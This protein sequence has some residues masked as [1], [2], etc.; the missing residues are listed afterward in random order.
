MYRERPA[1]YEK[2]TY[3][4]GFEWIDCISP[5]KCMVSFQRNG[6]TPEDILIVIANFANVEQKIRV[7]V[8]YQG[9]YREILNTDAACYGGENRM[10]HEVKQALEGEID[11]R[12]YSFVMKAAPLSVSVF[13]YKH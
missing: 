4:E 6:D 7:G 8:P 13:E 11:G 12:S 5:E 1:L 2:D 9:E 3:P 10:N